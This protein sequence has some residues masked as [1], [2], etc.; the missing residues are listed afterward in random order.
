[1]VNSIRILKT[2]SITNKRICSKSKFIT[3]RSTYSNIALINFDCFNNL[4]CVILEAIR[5][6]LKITDTIPF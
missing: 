2:Y 1:M 4:F 6:N 3:L 5:K